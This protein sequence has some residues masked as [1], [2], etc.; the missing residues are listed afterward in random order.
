MHLFKIRAVKLYDEHPQQEHY[1]LHVHN[2]YEI[3]CFLSGDAMYNVEGNLYPLLPGDILLLKDNESHNLIL[4]SDIPY[5]RITV[6]FQCDDGISEKLSKILLT[7]VL[8]RPIGQFNLYSCKEFS[9]T[10]WRY[11]LECICKAPDPIRQQIYLMTLLQE[12]SEVFPRIKEQS[13]PD[14][15]DRILQIT[16]YIDRHLAEPLSIQRICNRF[17]ISQAQLTR[18]F[19][20]SLA[21]T[22][23]AYV[24][25]KRLLLAHNLIQK[26]T[27]PTAA[28]LQCGFRDYSVFYRA[29]KK[30]FG[31]SPTDNRTDPVHLEKI[32]LT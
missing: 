14:S 30:K 26:G 16:H 20:K 15:V 25:T 10:Q 29:Y 19:K 24:L 7:P 6:H 17:Y 9:R 18:Q 8:D 21:T 28:Y 31:R 3:F 32:E 13:A 4:N 2:A 1:R 23:G 5:E 11:Y 22:V 12:I 27:K